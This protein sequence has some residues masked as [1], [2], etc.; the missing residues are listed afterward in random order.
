M[1]KILNVLVGGLY[2]YNIYKLG[3]IRYLIKL[4]FIR[5]K[6]GLRPSLLIDLGRAGL[7]NKNEDRWGSSSRIS[8]I[9][10][11]PN[12]ILTRPMSIK[13]LADLGSQSFLFIPNIRIVIQ[14]L[15]FL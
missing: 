5:S 8:Q 10:F 7:A 15:F 2:T 1:Y 14:L 12:Q 4:S 3:Y 11:R 6:I 9:R 13:F